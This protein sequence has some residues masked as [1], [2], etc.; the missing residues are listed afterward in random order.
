M[1]YLA[2]FQ[3]ALKEFV[4]SLDRSGVRGGAA[5]DEA[6]VPTKD[7]A[8]TTYT[9]GFDGNLGANR[10]SPRQLLAPHL[11]ELVCVEGI[12]TRCQ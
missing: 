12:A 8:S 9:I 7:P 5:E 11:G 3:S 6:G 10:C 4:L 2:P 1:H